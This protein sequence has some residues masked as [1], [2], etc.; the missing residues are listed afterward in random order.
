MARS[1]REP[2]PSSSFARLL[3][4]N[5]AA[6]AT[7]RPTHRSDQLPTG[8]Q[9]VGQ[10]RSAQDAPR[11]IKR[12]ILLCPETDETLDELVRFLRLGTRCRVTTSHVMRALLREVGP[13]L[14]DV[15]DRAA[16]LGPRR[17]PSNAAGCEEA[18]REFEELIATVFRWPV[19]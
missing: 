12:E 6:R 16:R 19:D 4:P 13:R 18:R 3:D 1:L 10:Q 17:L 11:R 7:S 5:A 2:P 8:P 14:Q 9:T 15:R